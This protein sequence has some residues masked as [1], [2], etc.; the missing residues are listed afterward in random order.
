MSN[1]PRDEFDRVPESSSRQGVHR[2]RMEQPKGGGLAIVISAGVIALLIGAVA[3]F[4]L[5]N[6][7]LP[8]GSQPVATQGAA[9]QAT[10]EPVEAINDDEN[11]QSSGPSEEPEGGAAPAVSEAPAEET[12]EPAESEAPSESAEPSPEAAAVDKTTGVVVLNST[13]VPGLAGN[14]SSRLTASGWPVTFTGN[15]AGAPQASSVVFYN[16]PDQLANAQAIAG[17]LGIEQLV[18]TADFQQPLTVVLGPGFS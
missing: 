4:V 16:G 14:A 5:P 11:K 12:E 7:N 2:E 8:G 18:D 1:Y 17:S 15:W 6:L 9:S 13:T 3:Y 10:D